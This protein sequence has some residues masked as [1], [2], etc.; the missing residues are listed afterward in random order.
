MVLGF[1]L[2]NGCSRLCL[3]CLIR[4]RRFVWF[5]TLFVVVLGREKVITIVIRFV[6]GMSHRPVSFPRCSGRSRLSRM[7]MISGRMDPQ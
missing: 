4:R 7:R 2:W 5:P 1:L 6:V 3:K